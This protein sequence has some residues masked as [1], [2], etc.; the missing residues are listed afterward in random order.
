MVA[1]MDGALPN[2]III[3]APKCGTTS[4]HNYLDAHESISMSRLKSDFFLSTGGTWE[5]G[6]D[7]YRSQFDP[8]AAV[9]GE[10]ST[11]Y[12]SLP[13]SEGTAPRMK[14]VVP[15]AKLIYMVR[16]PFDRM[17]SHYVQLAAMPSKITTLGNSGIETRPFAEAA[18]DPESPYLAASL[19]ATQLEAFLDH[20][21][22]ARILVESQERFL[23][24]RADVLRRIF[25]FL[26]VAADVAR[27]EYERLWEETRG[28]GRAYMLASRAAAKTQALGIH[29]PDALRW[30]VQRVLRSPVFGGGAPIPKP[31]V[32]REVRSALE[33]R[34][35]DEA[36]R[37]RK[38]SGCSFESWSV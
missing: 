30:P 31:T 29:L 23:T 19:Y 28:K 11:S 17:A 36:D 14:Q 22:P 18:L 7:W 16:D 5:R 10:G 38:I 12:T 33:P 37:L 8:S 26:G 20:Y 24:E 13:F 2:L 15:E 3:G 1:V 25:E 35:R 9:R 6:L 27:P 21:S 32:T 4:L 34:L